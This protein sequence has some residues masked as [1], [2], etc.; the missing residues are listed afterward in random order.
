MSS[1]VVENKPLNIFMKYLWY[2]LASAVGLYML[3]GIA[4][5]IKEFI[6]GLKKGWKQK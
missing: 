6:I 4:V 3:I 2:L 5:L 1:L